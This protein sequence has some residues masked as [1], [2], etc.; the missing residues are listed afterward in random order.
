MK[1]SQ[2]LSFFLNTQTQLLKWIFFCP[3]GVFF[4]Y[5]GPGLYGSAAHTGLNFLHR[6]A[7]HKTS[8]KQ[9]NE[10]CK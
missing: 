6:E 8:T 10:T 1:L 3:L 7:L 9:K 2:T 4:S 5:R